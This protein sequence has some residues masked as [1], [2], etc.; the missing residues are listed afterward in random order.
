[1]S[2]RLACAIACL[3]LASLARADV[4][5]DG[6]STPD[7]LP[8]SPD[9]VLVEGRSVMEV[10]VS[11]GAR[12]G[13]TLLHSFET[14]GLE[15]H[16]DLLLSDDL[17]I[18]DSLRTV[19]SRVT[20]GE[21]SRIDGRLRSTIGSAD[22]L[23]LNPAGV[24]FG[25]S[26]RIDV[27]GSFAASTAHELELGALRIPTGRADPVAPDALVSDPAV[28]GFLDAPLG[29][30]RVEGAQL[31]VGRVSLAGA[32]STA[33]PADLWLVGGDVAIDGGFVSALGGDVALVSVA[34]AGRVAGLGGP[35]PELTLDGV[36]ARGDV[37]LAG[38]ATVSSSA[39]SPAARLGG[40]AHDELVGRLGTLTFSPDAETVEVGDAG[41][42]TL[43]FR[44]AILP[45]GSGSIAIRAGDLRVADADVRSVTP[46]RLDAGDLDV[47]LSGDLELLGGAGDSGLLARSGGV[48]F[49]GSIDLWRFG[50]QGSAPIAGELTA[51][52]GGGE[53]RIRADEVRL[54]G[55]ALVSSSANGR[56]A[57][58]A[59]LVDARNVLVSGDAELPE[60]ASGILS[61]ARSAV[62]G[63]G[64]AGRIEIEASELLRIDAQGRVVALTEGQGAGGDVGVRAGRVEVLGGGVIDASTLA[65][66]G[67]APASGAGGTVEV[68]A[69]DGGI[70]VSGP[71]SSRPSRIGTT[72]QNSTGD[73]GVRAARGAADRD[74][75]PGRG[76]GPDD[77]ERGRRRRHAARRRGGGARGRAPG[78][79][80]HGHRRRGQRPHRAGDERGDPRRRRAGRRRARAGWGHRHR[81]HGAGPHPRQRS[82]RQRARRRRQ[83]RR[84]RRHRSALRPSRRRAHPGA[85]DRRPGR[86]DPDP[87]GP[88]LRPALQPHRREL[89]HRHRRQRRD[90]HL[91]GGPRGRGDRPARRL[92]RRERPAARPVRTARRRRRRRRRGG[93]LR[94]ARLR[95]PAPQPRPAAASRR[96][97]GRCARARRGRGRAA[98]DRRR[99]CR[100]DG[101]AR[102]ARARRGLARP[103][104]AAAPGAG[105][106]ARRRAPR[107]D[108]RALL[109]RRA[110]RGG[111][112]RL[113]GDLVRLGTSGGP[114]RARGAARRGP[115][116]DA[117]RPARGGARWLRRGALPLAVAGG[118]AVAGA[119]RPGARPGRAAGCGADPG[120]PAARG[121]GGGDRRARL[122]AGV[123][124]PAGGHLARRR[125]AAPGG[126]HRGPGRARRSAARGARRR[127]ER[128]ARRPGGLLRRPLPDGR[129]PAAHL[130]AAGSAAD[131]ARG[132]AG[133]HR[134]DR[135]RGT[136]DRRG[137]GRRERR[138]A[139]G[140]R[141][142]PAGRAARSRVARVPEPRRPPVRLARAPAGRL[143]RASAAARAWSSRC[144]PSC[145]A[146]RWR[147]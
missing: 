64:D 101:A 71:G 100:R 138:R 97:R 49:D 55:G 84:Q 67:A 130:G 98:A 38:G 107:R 115:G 69:G 19:I 3:A 122:R 99:R 10:P 8:W 51:E 11:R 85:R 65:R 117:A 144:P 32:D 54:S 116:R 92:R 18:G 61:S 28:F 140:G 141:R 87:R 2:A 124:G 133:P 25:P 110:P 83:P 39:I 14:L 24:V 33:T 75:R 118:A 121:G 127:R 96:A 74:R 35:A 137:P 68:R 40:L 48:P 132:A 90:P 89:G 43:Y 22:V 114:V 57:A 17:G 80:E 95:V 36:S 111:G 131:P 113:A 78:G 143:G 12:G 1:M 45:L 58:G 47:D 126:E 72:S 56:G 135:E 81:G 31:E 108:R 109:R 34:S 105:A 5:L 88:S 120:R 119:R 94:G 16:E 128:G 15:A 86:R 112:G 37:E 59:I 29:E 106:R 30:I 27:P 26:G 44:P 82:G 46:G 102:C 76:A 50:G 139:R 79:R 91:G 136:A 145:A 42:R 6:S 4:V 53:I 134:A 66:E 9:P 103:L 41:G 52:G 73:A 7:G 104:A 125:A 63:T 21:V 70:L 147:R 60:R 62:P 13:S 93:Q 142:P 77:G 129:A 146:S 123:P 20:G 23:L